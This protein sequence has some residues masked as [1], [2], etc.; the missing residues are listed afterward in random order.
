MD[1]YEVSVWDAEDYE[2]L[3]AEIS[4]DEE[5]LCLVSQE[6]GFSTL[7]IEVHPRRDG[8]PWRLKLEDFEGRYRRRS[9]VFGSCEGWSQL[10]TEPKVDGDAI[11]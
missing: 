10:E 8:Q 1:Q 3:I 2:D 9:N 11:H 5:F 6:S 4:L 7:D